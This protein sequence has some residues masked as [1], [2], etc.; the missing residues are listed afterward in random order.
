VPVVT[1]KNEKPAVFMK[2][3]NEEEFSGNFRVNIR[4]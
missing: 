1:A 2:K 4:N 3:K